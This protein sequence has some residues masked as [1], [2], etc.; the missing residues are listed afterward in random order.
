M[1]TPAIEE[2]LL[3]SPS[4]P[5]VA[6]EQYSGWIY[7]FHLAAAPGIKVGGW[8]VWHQDQHPRSQPYRPRNQPTVAKVG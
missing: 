1:M 7:T 8:P 5:P 2:Q 3:G 4:Q 6:W